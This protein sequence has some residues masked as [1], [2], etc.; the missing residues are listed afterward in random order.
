MSDSATH[1]F[2]TNALGVYKSTQSIGGMRVTN[3]SAQTQN[4]INVTTY[5]VK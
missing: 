4:Y 3:S 5:G 1:L 2:G